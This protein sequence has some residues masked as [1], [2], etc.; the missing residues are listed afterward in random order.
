MTVSDQ[1]KEVLRNKL[2]K[3]GGRPYNEN[4]NASG[5][6]YGSI[7]VIQKGKQY[8]LI[9]ELVDRGGKMVDNL[10]KEYSSFDEMWL[11]LKEL[12]EI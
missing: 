11:E 10:R 9:W 3:S 6:R 4:Y 12:L 5:Q 7:T 2:A 1:L 8:S